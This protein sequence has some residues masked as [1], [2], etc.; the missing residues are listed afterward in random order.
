MT[1]ILKEEPL[2]KRTTFRIGGPAQRLALPESMEELCALMRSGDVRFVLGGGA[3]LLVSDAGVQ[4]TTLALGQRFGGVEISDTREG[5]ARVKVGAAMGLTTLAGMMMK[6]SLSGLEFGFGIPG[7]LGGALRMNAGARG[8]EIKDITESIDIVTANGMQETIMASQAG[9]GYRSSEFPLGC[10]IT[11][12]T[13]LLRQGNM[14]LIHAAMRGGYMERKASQ[15]LESPSAGSVYKNPPGDYA[16]RLIES[17]GLKGERVGEAMVSPKH[18]NFIVNLGG[19]KARD[20]YQLMLRIEK[21]VYER[22][23]A[24]LEREIKLVGV[25]DEK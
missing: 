5:T 13:L 16:G 11:G 17:C 22:F 14:E 6:R 4:G 19:A 2:W 10:V 12:A 23:G 25:F 9:F 20:V 21:R 3:N 15:P 18:A 24:R 1:K 8:A 7:L